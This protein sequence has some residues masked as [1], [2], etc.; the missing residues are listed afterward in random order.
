MQRSSVAI[1]GAGFSGTLLALHLSRVC[2]PGTRI[3]L[4]E[5]R[6]EFGPGLAYSTDCS[7]HVLNVP[8]GRM[9]AFQDQPLHFLQWLERQP[10]ETL[11]GLK[12]NTASFVPRLRY[13][14][15]LRELLANAIGVCP[16]A[17][18]ELVR[19]E[20]V[21]LTREPKGLT[22]HLD[23]GRTVATAIAVIAT[24][25]D[26]PTEPLPTLRD[27]P[28]YRNNPWPPDIADDL[29]SDAAV[30]LIGT[31]L[32]AVDVI[33]L[34][35]RRG[36]QGP[37]HA[38]SRRGL[39]PR[40][41]AG[42]PVPSVTFGVDLV[43]RKPRDLVRFIR[44]ECRRVSEG[45][46]SWQAAVDAMRPLT[47]DIWRNWP[48]ADRR[49]FLT[50]ARPWWDV[51][52]H[53]LAPEI[54]ERVEAAKASGQ[55]RIHAGQMSGFAS[56]GDWVD[57]LWRPRGG[58]AEA[59]LR[60]SRVINCIGPATDVATSPG[61]LNQSLL[62]GGLGQPDAS[63]L[64]FAMTSDHA[65]E[66]NASEILFGIGPICRGLLLESTAIPEIRVQCQD[67][68][69]HIASLLKRRTYTGPLKHRSRQ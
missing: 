47:Q 34:L 23:D 39:L 53:R 66:G 59:T 10:S 52:R 65:L 63:R 13:G 15:Y 41:H 43:P 51:H 12:P 1:I 61:R 55:L 44:N 20:V 46:G 18:L 68:A 11:E 8:A 28:F 62:R 64:G 31:G 5:R 17:T 21:S 54:A 25:N 36:H 33:L 32:T 37:I 35:S 58:I 7:A 19:G 4:I 6:A 67:L 57:V 38:L 27:K 40:T 22:L 30:L 3:C 16:K 49:Q 60:V 48:H 50:H 26:A 42:V 24:G 29:P 45:G 9:S 69:N 14:R 2:S 56:D